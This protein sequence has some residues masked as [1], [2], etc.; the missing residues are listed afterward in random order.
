M[1][2]TQTLENVK[3]T[4]NKNDNWINNA[5]SQT[6]VALQAQTFYDKT[7]LTRLLPKLELAKFAQKSTM[8]RH[9]G[10]KINWRK[11][12]SLPAATTPLTEGTTPSGSSITMAQVESTLKQYGD[13]VQ[14]S[15]LIDVVGIDP[16]VVE[17]TE[18]L[19][20]Q[21]GLTIDTVIREA[22]VVGTNVQYAGGKAATEN[23]AKTDVITRDEVLKAVRTLKNNNAMRIDGYYIGI[24][25]PDMSF[26]LQK[27]PDWIE[28]NK[29]NNGG[30][31][32]YDGEV[33]KLGGVRFIETTNLKVKTG[34][35]ETSA[36]VHCGLI[37]GKNA[38]GIAD[39]EGMQAMKPRT[40]IK[41]VG[42]SGTE[43]PLN[44]RGT[45]GWKAY[46][47]AT[48]LDNLSIIRLECGVSD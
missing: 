28:V 9:S 14:H 40:I 48:I 25:D 5:G 8:S 33:G 18:V 34:A 43:D 39:V 41:P 20:E 17:T 35:G 24:I 47:A 37:F 19:G 32:I 11:F 3:T 1:S 4:T 30:T 21:A 26:D 44:Q 38:Y 13:F 45:I 31:A 6:Q 15:D 46:F 16:F 10:N 27:D 29:Y 42:S 2:T 7:L 12:N 36:D 22:I 23:V